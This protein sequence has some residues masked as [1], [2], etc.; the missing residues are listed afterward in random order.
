MKFQMIFSGQATQ[1]ANEIKNAIK[2]FEVH[3]IATL[4]EALKL[5]CKLKA[6]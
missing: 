6:I 3:G 1:V 5:D 4:G 2:D